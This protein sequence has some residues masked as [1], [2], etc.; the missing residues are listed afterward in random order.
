MRV[1]KHVGAISNTC[2][3]LSMRNVFVLMY[4]DPLNILIVYSRY[5]GTIG[6]PCIFKYLRF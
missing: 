4:R 5:S 3:N 1:H 6:S 2:C